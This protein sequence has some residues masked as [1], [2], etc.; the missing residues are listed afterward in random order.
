MKC[1]TATFLRISLAQ[2]V[3]A[4]KDFDVLK[5]F[6]PCANGYTG[7]EAVPGTGCKYYHECWEGEV[8]AQK[9]CGDPLLYNKDRDYCDFPSEVFCWLAESVCPPTGSPESS[10]SEIPTTKTPPPVTEMPPTASP[11]IEKPSTASPFIEKPPTYP[12]LQPAIPKSEAPTVGDKSN[13]TI[14]GEIGTSAILHVESKRDLIERYVM[15]SYNPSGLPYPSKSYTY[16]NFIQSL[17]I[18]GVDG[19]GA[20]FKFEL[21]EGIR[22]KYHYGLVNLAAFLANSMVESIEADTC[23]ELN[24][25]QVSGRHAISNSCGQESRSYQDETCGVNDDIFSCEVVPGMDIMAVSAS[26]TASPPMKCEPGSGQTYH[27][28]YWD[29]SSGTLVT[30]AP[31]SNDLG[32]TDTEGCCFWGRG[33]LLTRGV[34]NIGKVNYFLG[35]R[36]ADL[37][38]STLYPTVDFCQY[39]EATCAGIYTDELRWTIAFFEWAERVQR[40]TKRNEWNYEQKLR[41]FIDSGM[42]DDS[43]INSVSRIFSRK[44][45]APECSEFEVLQLDKRRSNFY[46]IIND[47][48][49]IKTLLDSVAPTRQPITP[50]PTRSPVRIATK[51]PTPWPTPTVSIIST[52][53]GLPSPETVAMQS[54]PDPTVDWHMISPHDGSPDPQIIV[55]IIPNPTENQFKPIPAETFV[56]TVGPS[57]VAPT[58]TGGDDP[59]NKPT[60]NILIG[61]EGNGTVLSSLISLLVLLSSITY[62]AYFVLSQL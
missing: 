44:C 35:K 15:I 55:P 34:C 22:D 48:F 61:L 3:F 51:Y 19:F 5:C 28:G 36:G 38:R 60:G 58:L 43:F 16:D 49:D 7:N 12:P 26:S 56:A 21:W 27:S 24:W 42:D 11:F 23:D 10:P 32:R 46:L 57:P 9:E 13:P 53:A 50:R 30:G 45:H 17:K 6:T 62:A 41:E 25:Q 1:I 2:V 40:Y 39:P 54:T 8:R 4:Q 37:G 31:Y 20:D 33:A 29:A 14:I 59:S 52:P 47:I 18:M